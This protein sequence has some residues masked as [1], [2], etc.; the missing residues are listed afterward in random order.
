MIR[1]S[2]LNVQRAAPVCASQA[3]STPASSPHTTRPATTVG[4]D[5]TASA[6]AYCHLSRPVASSSAYSL[7]SSSPTYTTPFAIAA[8]EVVPAPSSCFQ[9]TCNFS[10]SAVP[11]TPVL[12]ELPR[13]MGQ[14]VP[15]AGALLG[16]DAGADA[17]RVVASCPP[18]ALTQTIASRIAMP[19]PCCRPNR[20]FIVATLMSSSSSWS[21]ATLADSTPPIT[22]AR[23]SS[24]A[25]PFCVRMRPA[26]REAPV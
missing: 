13:N 7:P 25:G 15:V 8:V 14:S 23:R 18:D 5:W 24:T 20:R 17:G 11:A 22:T 16:A 10:G 2:V 21:A 19:S 12:A 1:S 4:D 26:T 9:R 3:C 6:A